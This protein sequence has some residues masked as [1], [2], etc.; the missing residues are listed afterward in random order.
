MGVQPVLDGIADGKQPLGHR[1][2]RW[3]SHDVDVQR[4]DLPATPAFDD[5]Q[6]ASGQTGIDAHHTHRTLPT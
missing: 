3:C 6:P 1:R 2:I 5:R 4:D